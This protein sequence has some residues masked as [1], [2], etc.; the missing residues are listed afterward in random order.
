MR[1]ILVAGALALALAVPA[2]AAEANVDPLT[3]L[4]DHCWTYLHADH[5][6]KSVVA[7]FASFLVVIESPGDEA[8]ARAM[9]DDLAAAFPD[10]QVR[11]LLHTHHHGH[12]LATIDP[13]LARDVTVVTAPANADRLAK[14]TA[15][16]ERF[17]RA[18]LPATQGLILAD[19]LNRLV[20][21]VIED[22]EY[23]V[24]TAQYVN[25]E[26]PAQQVMVTGCLYNKPL[27]QHAVVNQ[28]KP[29]LRR[30]LAEHAPDVITLVPTNTCGAR[31]Y[32][33]VCTVAMLDATLA[34]GLH[35][36]AVA[37]RLAAMSLEEIAAQMDD[38]AAEYRGRVFEA[39]DL[40]VC[41]NTLR[42]V[43]HD[44]ERAALLAEAATRAFPDDVSAAYWLGL[45][46]LEIGDEDGADGAWARALELADGSE[47]RADYVARMASTRERVARERDE[48]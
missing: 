22:D 30:Y 4:A 7:E 35:P 41:A 17:R 29:A 5:G 13:W 38:L 1:R 9:L 40:L 8:A 46:R 12:S 44:G 45:M 47:E 31:G 36:E 37:D 16:P 34:E 6:A 33:D 14:R 10:K 27:G 2:A 21:H 19:D 43:R 42:R 32:E 39:Y 26:F 24:P 3:P 48:G 25:I 11:F 15:N 23:D 18:Y 28:R 20:V